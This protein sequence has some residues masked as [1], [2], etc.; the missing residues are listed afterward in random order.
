MAKDSRARRRKIDV[1]LWL[2]G[3]ACFWCSG[4]MILPWQNTRDHKRRLLRTAVT[5]DELRPRSMGG[6]CILENQVMACSGCNHARGAQ[7][8]PA[9]AVA[10]HRALLVEHGFA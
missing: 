2:Y 4:E 8:A 7:M 10:R 3:N 1:L 5:L 9:E 6:P